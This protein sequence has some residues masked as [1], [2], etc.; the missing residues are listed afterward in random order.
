MFLTVMIEVGLYITKTLKS[1]LITQKAN[2]VINRSEEKRFDDYYNRVKTAK[3]FDSQTSSE[4][5]LNAPK[6]TVDNEA[7]IDVEEVKMR[8]Q[9]DASSEKKT[10]SEPVSKKEK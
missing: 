9:K 6:N 3:Q 2:R 5:H 1:D 7:E 8:N 4:G 10:T